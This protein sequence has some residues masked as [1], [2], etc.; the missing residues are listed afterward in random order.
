MHARRCESDGLVAFGRTLPVRELVAV[1]CSF[2]H[3]SLSLPS[4][5]TTIYQSFSSLGY[6]IHP[7]IWIWED[8]IY[9]WC[10]YRSFYKVK[11]LRYH[12]S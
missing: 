11:N 12:G 6:G 5:R 2:R 1:G 4:P 9:I 8:S 3:G 7:R 10:N